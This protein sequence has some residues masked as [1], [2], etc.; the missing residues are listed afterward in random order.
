MTDRDK[1]IET[2]KNSDRDRQTQRQ[3]DTLTD[4]E[5]C[6]EDKKC[7][8]Q[9]DFKKETG[10]GEKNRETKKIETQKCIDTTDI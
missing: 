6:R 1:G 8:L 7:D 9:I 3:I 2:E 5:T 10:R 4:T